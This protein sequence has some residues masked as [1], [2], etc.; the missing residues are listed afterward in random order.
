MFKIS[1]LLLIIVGLATITLCIIDVFTIK[2]L[3]TEKVKCI[4]KKNNQFEDEWCIEKRFC[5]YFGIV[6]DEKCQR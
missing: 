5:S 1:V 6:G 4:D 3:G 2:E